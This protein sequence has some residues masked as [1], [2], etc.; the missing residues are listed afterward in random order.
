[1]KPS[2]RDASSCPLHS[3]SSVEADSRFCCCYPFSCAQVLPGR[4]ICELPILP[5]VLEE[6]RVRQVYRLPPLPLFSGP[7]AGDPPLP[8]ALPIATANLPSPLT[9]RAPADVKC[10]LLLQHEEVRVYLAENKDFALEAA[11]QQFYHWLYR[12]TARLVPEGGSQPAAEAAAT[13]TTTT[14][15][16]EAPAS[17]AK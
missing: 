11:D 5:S 9:A 2:I 1:M 10:P 6:A 13:T 3:S 14:T 17:S 12:R 8:I 7:A 15:A 4:E 16:A